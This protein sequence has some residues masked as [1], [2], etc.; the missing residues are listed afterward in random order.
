MAEDKFLINRQE[1]GKLGSLVSN[2]SQNHSFNPARDLSVSTISSYSLNVGKL[3]LF[4]NLNGLVFE[5]NQSGLILIK[6]SND[7]TCV[8]AFHTFALLIFTNFNKEILIGLP[9]HVINDFNFNGGFLLIFAH[10]DQ[11]F[12]VLI[13]FRGLGSVVNGAHKEQ[14]VFR[15]FLLDGNFNET[16][17]LSHRVMSAFESNTSVGNHLSHLPVLQLLMRAFQLNYTL[18]FRLAYLLAMGY[19]F[20]EVF[21]LQRAN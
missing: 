16:T 6:N 2:F 19:S 8:V 18:L 17:G 7:A 14:K 9:N 11:L 12:K 20:N 13:I 3:I 21:N 4:A 5:S 1:V 15:D 10:S